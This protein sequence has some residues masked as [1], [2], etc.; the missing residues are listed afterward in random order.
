M[1]HFHWVLFCPIFFQFFIEIFSSFFCFLV[2]QNCCPPLNLNG[3][4]LLCGA[5]HAVVRLLALLV[6]C[7]CVA[8]SFLQEP[9]SE[10]SLT[11]VGPDLSPVLLYH[12]S[13]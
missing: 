3:L 12:R 1:F 6:L 8:G 5:L 9:R 4:S 10:L 13:G 2:L 11:S 7:F